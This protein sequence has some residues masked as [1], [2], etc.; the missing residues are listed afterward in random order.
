M[1]F[2]KPKKKPKAS[3]VQTSRKAPSPIN[4]YGG[5][6]E[7]QALA[8]M[9]DSLREAVP[10][11]DAAIDKILRLIG[12]VEIK[13]TT[14][15]AQ[16]YMDNFL[17]DVQVGACG[18]G[19][20]AFLHQYLDRLL[21]WGTA[22]CEIIPYSDGTIAAIYCANNKDINL[23]PG[24]NPLQIKICRNIPGEKKEIPHPDRVIVS[25]LN[26]LPGEIQ[27]TSILKGLPFVSSVLLKIINTVGVNWERIGNLRYAVTY[28]PSG[29]ILDA[30]LGADTLTQI[31]TEWEKA[32]NSTE[33]VRDFVAVGDVDIKVIGADNQI[34]DSE[35]PIRQ[36]LEQ[37][38]AKL[39][40]PPFMLGLSWSSTERMSQQQADILTS[41]LE[42]YRMLL[43]PVIKK[44]CLWELRNAGFGDN[45]KIHWTDINLQDQVEKARAELYSAQAENL[46]KTE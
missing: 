3:V 43:N 34:L 33:G 27:G 42:S 7:N 23:L 26:P 41:E 19:I 39:G 30:T 6:G 1:K 9:F 28:K 12:N 18:R 40:I 44:I 4:F 32:M 5:W 37:I 35:V 29:N 17:D 38:V 21:T 10:I 45:I 22:V 31:S 36:M 11:I 8:G 13:C 14:P 25:A 15:S 2:E 20:K 46:S 16:K 24:E